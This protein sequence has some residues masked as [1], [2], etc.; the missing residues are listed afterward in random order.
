M[1][2]LEGRC[3]GCLEGCAVG[4]LIGCL[5]GCAVGCRVGLRVGCLDGGISYYGGEM[6]RVI[7]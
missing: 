5:E 7:S 2:C 6:R 1:T 4:R 3:A